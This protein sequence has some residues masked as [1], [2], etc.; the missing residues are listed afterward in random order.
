MALADAIAQRNRAMAGM[1]AGGGMP[2][3]MPQ[4]M[5]NYPMGMTPE[6]AGLS[7]EAARQMMA[8]QPL[9]PMTPAA[10]RQ[11]AAMNGTGGLRGGGP[12]KMAP[13]R[14]KSKKPAT[15]KRPVAKRTGR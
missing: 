4:P 14:R 2:P 3:A 5:P 12:K 6:P 10:T 1:M 13:A 7:M 11:F 8:A 9:A 15:G